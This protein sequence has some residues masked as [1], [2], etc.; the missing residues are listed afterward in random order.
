M[1]I[2][3]AARLDAVRR[4]A[5]LDTPSDG[6]FDRIAAIAARMLSVPVALVSIVD[7]DRIWFKARHGLDVPQID[8]AP[9]LCASAIL[10]DG[11]WLVENASVDVRTLDNPLVAG[12]FGLRFYAGVPLTSKDGHNLGTLC[13]MDR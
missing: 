12:E 9:G 4:Y 10:N 11:P 1:H 7:E 2:D 13:V 3:E 8:R 5:I 6:A